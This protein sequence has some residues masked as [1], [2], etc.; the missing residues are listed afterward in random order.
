M[1]ALNTVPAAANLR[2]T[3]CIILGASA[4]MVAPSTMAAE[5]SSGGD[6][7]LTLSGQVNRALLWA[8]DGANSRVFHVDNDNS[9]TRF[10]LVG[11]GSL[12]QNV[13]VGAQIT[14]AVIVSREL[15]IPCVVS[16][17]DATRRIPDGA[18]LEVNGSMGTVT[19]LETS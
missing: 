6:V 1:F 18:L 16:V 10:R 9:S 11:N 4:A 7:S 15:G 19:V 14:H 5:V 13:D 3:F 12:N 17:T 8:D 2:R